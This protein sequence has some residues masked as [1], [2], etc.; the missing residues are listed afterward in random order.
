MTSA[1]STADPGAPPPASQQPV[2]FFGGG[3][4]STGLM[5]NTLPVSGPHDGPVGAYWV[6]MPGHCCSLQMSCSPVPAG[7]SIGPYIS[8]KRHSLVQ[9]TPSIDV[10]TALKSGSQ[11]AP[12]PNSMPSERSA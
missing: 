2:F 9:V 8:T 6:S 11:L 4:A 12:Q 1:A 7:Q 10:A 5:P 3:V